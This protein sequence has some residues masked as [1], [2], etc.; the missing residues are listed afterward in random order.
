MILLVGSEG[1]MGTRYKRTLDFLGRKYSCYDTKLSTSLEEAAEGCDRAI[2]ATPTAIHAKSIMDILSVMPSK[3]IL[4]EKPIDKDL[5]VLKDILKKCRDA[6]SDIRMVFQY[7]KVYKDDGLVGP[8]HYNYFRH[9][10]DSLIW[11]CIQIIGLSRG[12]VSLKE[13]SPMWSCAINGQ[14]LKIQHMDW[15]YV[16]YISD[17][18]TMPSLCIGP[19]EILEI[20]E[21]VHQYINASRFFNGST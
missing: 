9:G 14:M 6:N 13:T 16:D 2:V 19:Q 5:T 4:C 15:A 21:K 8:S 20:H 3:P 1:N 11:D 17:W 10:D 7:K 18:L 12:T